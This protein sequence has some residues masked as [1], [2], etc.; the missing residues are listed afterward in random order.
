MLKKAL[1]SV[2]VLLLSTVSVLAADSTETQVVGATLSGNQINVS[3]HNPDASPDTARVQVSVGLAD[4]TIR[5]LVTGNVTVEGGGTTS[6]SLTASDAIV[7][8][9]EDP[10]PISPAN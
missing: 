3:L 7:A 10:Q 8:I 2:F 6:V 9:I 4:G 5:T 1:V